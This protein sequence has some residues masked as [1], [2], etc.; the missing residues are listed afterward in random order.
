[1]KVMTDFT[2]KLQ[3]LITFYIPQLLVN[4][5]NY[6]VPKVL[7]CVKCNSKICISTTFVYLLIMFFKGLYKGWD[8]SERCER[9]REMFGDVGNHH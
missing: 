2:K 9:L 5:S 4:D 8:S 6:I 3:F 1:M 7:N